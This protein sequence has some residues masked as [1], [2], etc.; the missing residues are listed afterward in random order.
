MTFANMALVTDDVEAAAMAGAGVGVEEGRRRSPA[1]AADLGD[2]SAQRAATVDWLVE[3]L[4]KLHLSVETL[5]LTVSIFD[6]F[7]ARRKVRP[8]RLQL[9]GVA[10]ALVAAKFEEVCPPEVRDFVFATRHACTKEAILDME[11]RLLMALEFCVRRPAER[12]RRLRPVQ[13]SGAGRVGTPRPVRAPR[14]LL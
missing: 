4:E 2:E 13:P 3:A 11:V 1:A 7:L 8:E 14:V 6:R 10:A 12:P 5:F 9:V